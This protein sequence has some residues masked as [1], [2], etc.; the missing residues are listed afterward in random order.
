MVKATEPGM[1]MNEQVVMTSAEVAVFLKVSLG[2]VR[3]W[4]RNGKLKGYR[5]GGRGDWRY[6]RQDVLAFLY[7]TD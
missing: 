2:A 1:D 5:L 4:A 3:R 6:L 7:G